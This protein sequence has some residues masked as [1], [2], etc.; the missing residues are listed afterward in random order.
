MGTEGKVTAKSRRC[1]MVA[2]QME[3]GC[4]PSNMWALRGWE[5]KPGLK[6]SNC[7]LTSLSSSSR[8]PTHLTD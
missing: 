3:E 8:E 5:R 6:D 7:C 2:L 1:P 4:K